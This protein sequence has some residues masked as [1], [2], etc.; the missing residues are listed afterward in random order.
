MSPAELA[1]MVKGDFANA[2]AASTPGGIEA[3]EAKGQRDLVSNFDRL[4]KKAEIG[5]HIDLRLFERLGFTFGADIDDVFVSVVPPA[6]WTMKATEHSMWS[7]LVD[8]KGRERGSVFY[9]AAFYDRSAHVTLRSRFII[10]SQ[11]QGDYPDYQ[12]RCVVLDGETTVHEEPWVARYE[13]IATQRQRCVDYLKQHFP[14]WENVEAYWDDSPAAAAVTSTPSAKTRRTQDEIVARY[15]ERAANDP[16]GFE[17]H[18][19]LPYLDFEHANALG[20][21]K[22]DTTA[23][24]WK[25]IGDQV[26]AVRDRMVE[27][28]S[29]AW[30]KANNQRGISAS[31]SIAH[32]I[33]WLWLDGADALASEIG[34]YVNYG[35]PQ[36]TRICEYLGLDVAKYQ[37]IT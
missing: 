25:A 15:K 14:D 4:P 36:L 32:Y 2:I 8:D 37:D 21:L 23:E 35:K 3:Q 9:K 13:E 24:E 30:E 34:D 11:H 10:A 20:I 33:A 18:E 31:R 28:M 27:Y 12:W 16:F 6:G 1:A 22:P 17:V 29:F 26:P 19:Y 5:G 7:R